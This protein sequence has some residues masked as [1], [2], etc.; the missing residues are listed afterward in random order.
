MPWWLWGVIVLA[1]LYLILR[2]RVVFRP[3]PGNLG[4]R[5]GK[6]AECPGTPNCVATQTELPPFQMAPI[7]FPDSPE[8][9]LARMETALRSLPRTRIVE[10]TPGYLHAECRSFLFRFVDDVECL[11]DAERK[12]IHFRSASRLG[13]SDFGVNRRRLEEIR[14]KMKGAL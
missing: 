6:L 14:G 7:P 12:V 2:L 10:K 5:E 8:Q 11:V 3:A 13:R 9:A 1:A 4:V